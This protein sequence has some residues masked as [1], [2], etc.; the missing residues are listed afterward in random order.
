LRSVPSS[1]VL[2]VVPRPGREERLSSWLNRLALFYAMP[3]ASFLE[4]CSL[5]GVDIAA[6]EWRLGDDEAI[7][8]AT[9]IG[10]TVDELRMMTFQ[11]IARHARPMIYRGGGNSC[12][13]CPPDL[14]RKTAAFPWNFWCV[15]HNVRLIAR[16][17]ENLVMKLP[18]TTL[19]SL[20]V[21][22]HQ[23]AMRLAAWAQGKDT[24]APSVPQHLDFL[25]TRYR[26]PRSPS[27][28]SPLPQS[29]PPWPRYAFLLVVPEYDRVAPAFDRPVRAGVSSLTRGSLLQK[30]ALTVALGRIATDP[31]GHVASV[32]L[33]SDYDGEE[34]LHQTLQTWPLELLNRIY[35]RL[36]RLRAARR[37][38]AE[39]E[40]SSWA[41]WKEHKSQNPDSPSLKIVRRES[42]N[43]ARS[44]RPSH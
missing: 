25:T 31:V 14:R 24:A 10:M 7:A 15:E 29:T 35:A 9:R 40:V 33:A 34:W 13:V 30:Y 6:L 8:L 26:R 36:Y 32:L 22:A 41:A 1:A 44:R 18:E 38:A 23:G 4:Y 5:N 11:E 21:N 39:R 27:F 43:H 42:Q 2:P 28:E 20:D 19:T 12:P 17:G 16:D 3:V 37:N